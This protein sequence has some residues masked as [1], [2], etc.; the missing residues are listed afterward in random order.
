MK[1]VDRYPLL[2]FVNRLDIT[3]YEFLAHGN[4]VMFR[5]MNKKGHIL[6][7][8]PE[9]NVPVEIILQEIINIGYKVCLMEWE[10]ITLPMD[11]DHGNG[12]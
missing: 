1:F 12:D 9:R 8:Q 3:Q 7:Y 2:P 11:T 6:T 10:V 5:I 4:A